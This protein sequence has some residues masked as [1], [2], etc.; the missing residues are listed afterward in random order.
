MQ[1][2]TRLGAACALAMTLALAGCSDPAPER[3][4]AAAETVTTDVV[5]TQAR[6]DTLRALGTVQARESVT[7]TAKVS[8]TVEKVHFASGDVVAAG[9]RSEE[10]RVGNEGR[11]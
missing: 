11:I 4:A 3:G 10:R 7:V 8:E 9:A 2:K 1:L 6:N 5:R